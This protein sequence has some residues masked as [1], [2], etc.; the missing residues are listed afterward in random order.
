MYA[1]VRTGEISKEFRNVIASDMDGYVLYIDKKRGEFVLVLQ[2]ILG[3]NKSAETFVM[4]GAVGEDLPV[5]VNVE[6]LTSSARSVTYQTED[7]EA[8]IRVSCPED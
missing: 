3:D 7:G 5:L 4:E 8:E 1:N 6:R 2:P